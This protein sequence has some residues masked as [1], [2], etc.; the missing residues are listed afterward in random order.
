MI[1]P[2]VEE[3]DSVSAASEVDDTSYEEALQSRPT[4]RRRHWSSSRRRTR[5]IPQEPSP[6]SSPP[7][8]EA[9]RSSRLP[10]SRLPYRSGAENESFPLATSVIR[11]LGRRF[12]EFQ[13]QR[14]LCQEPPSETTSTHKVWGVLLEMPERLDTL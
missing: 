11:L 13:A 7:P 6:P 8:E 9:T 4:R 14:V 3:I 2:L 5:E 10:P 1:T 12:L